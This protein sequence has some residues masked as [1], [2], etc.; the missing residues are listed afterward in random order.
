MLLSS[1]FKGSHSQSYHMT[2]RI[3]L[4]TSI[5][6][7]GEIMGTRMRGRLAKLFVTFLSREPEIL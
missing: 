3:G 7:I 4:P 2:C 6:H 5:S 1:C